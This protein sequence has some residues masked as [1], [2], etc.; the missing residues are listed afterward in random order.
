V[1]ETQRMNKV[2]PTSART[3]DINGAAQYLSMS[4]SWIR[5]A[6]A[7]NRLPYIRIG[8]SIRFLYTDLDSFLHSHRAGL[9]EEL[10][11]AGAGKS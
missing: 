10:D 11:N 4:K 9:A 6:I 2:L 1:D 7:Q 5:V 3:T 8:R